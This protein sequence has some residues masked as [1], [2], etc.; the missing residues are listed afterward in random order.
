[1]QEGYCKDCVNFRGYSNE[2]YW[3]ARDKAEVENYDSCKCFEEE[4]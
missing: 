4:E 2:G 3:C 1:M